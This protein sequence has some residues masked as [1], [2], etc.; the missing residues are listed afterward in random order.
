M[1]TVS[2][3]RTRTLTTAGAAALS[4]RTAGIRSHAGDSATPDPAV[5]EPALCAQAWCSPA[6]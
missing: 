4:V 3:S 1:I 6:L 5:M 2:L